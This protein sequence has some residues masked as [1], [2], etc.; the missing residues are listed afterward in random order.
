MMNQQNQ[1]AG[2]QGNE[3]MMRLLFKVL[4]KWY[5]VL[6]CG[7]IGLLAGWLVNRY[8]IPI[9]S[10]NS[11]LVSKKYENSKANPLMGA[12]LDGN[13]MFT[14]QPDFLLEMALIKSKDN[15]RETLKRLN[16]GVSYYVQGRVKLTESYPYGAIHLEWDSSSMRVPY[17]QMLIIKDVQSDGT[18]RLVAEDNEL[19]ALLAGH[20]FRFNE[21]GAFEGFRFKLKT[22]KRDFQTFNEQE[23]HFII[24]SPG[25]LLGYYRS[26]I[27]LSWTKQNSSLIDVN[28]TG[29]NPQKDR[30]FLNT[31]FEVVVEHA[32][33]SKNQYATN[34][35]NFIDGLL[36]DVADSLG[37][38]DQR[39]DS[40]QAG[41]W[42]YIAGSEH[43][44]E[45]VEEL[46]KEQLAIGLKERY[47][48]YLEDYLIEHRTE[49][50][51]A[52]NVVGLDIP[53]LDDLVQKYVEVKLQ[54]KL[55]KVEANANNP[56]VNKAVERKARL[57][58]N[59]L[60]NIRSMRR[61]FTQNKSELEG[62][63]N[64]LLAN[65]GNYQSSSRKLTKMN[66]IYQVNENLYNL[67]LEKKTEASIARA[68]TTSDYEVVNAPAISYLPLAPNTKKN[69]M[70]GGVVGLAIPIGLIVLL[71]FL[72]QKLEYREDA[73]R[74]TGLKTIGTIGESD[75]RNAAFTR[76]KGHLA[77]GFRKL[78]ANL[79]YLNSSGEGAKTILV[80][81]TIAG[82]GKSFNSVN[83]AYTYALAGQ[84]T[85][86]VG[87][88]LRKPTLHQFFEVDKSDGLSNYL[89]GHRGLKE[90]I[91]G[92]ACEGL[93]LVVSGDIP[94]NP[95]ELLLSDKMEDFLKVA[96]LKYD[97]I[98]IDTPPVSLVSDTIPLLPWVDHYLLVTRYN[99]SIKPSLAHVGEFIPE[100]YR[101][102]F[103]LIYNGMPKRKRG[104]GYGYGYG[105]YGHGYQYGYGYG[106]GYYEEEAEKPGWF[107]RLLKR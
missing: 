11:Q 104:Y 45:K 31:F 98:V 83:L 70:M 51:F 93:D 6:V 99:R 36:N 15:V 88:D 100:E 38:F 94:P 18:Y 43:L 37:R 59:I 97:V 107:G 101:V 8:T 48:D 106:S 44:F 49:E 9:Y 61:E 57:E 87:A 17:D 41:N 20:Q 74:L 1:P 34:S 21:W 76:P 63:K 85:L 92:T 65:V 68:S 69:L 102:H 24:N 90:I 64:N 58:N 91:R 35:I 3:D 105:N 50:V 13:S 71:A 77:E 66:S 52:P 5:L 7:F 72:N 39:I 23:Q 27:N 4:D 80:T 79:N 22:S 47:I 84:R 56:L 46:Q 82:E 89:A 16:F 29:P 54:E 2:Q 32:L 62:N 40:F 25:A 55:N 75:D 14:R 33:I 19:N 67:L 28:M 10:V 95:A 12:A 96:R 26:R 103:H 53:L 60:E 78:R 81:S 30:D 42:K 73:E 86:L